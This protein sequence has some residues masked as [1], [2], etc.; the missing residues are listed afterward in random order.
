LDQR[1]M[2]TMLVWVLEGNPARGFYEALGAQQTENRKT[3]VGAQ[4]LS[5]VAYLWDDISPMLPMRPEG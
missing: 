5:E 2:S 1:G 4:A 3:S